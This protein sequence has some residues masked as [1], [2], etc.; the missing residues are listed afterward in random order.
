M[1]FR[2]AFAA[3]AL[4]LAGAASA[5]INDTLTQRRLS[6]PAATVGV[7]LPREDWVLL[8]EQRNA[9]G[10]VAYYMLGSE[11]RQLVL[12]VYLDRASSCHAADA[13]LELALKNTAYL[14]AH[15]L[16]KS[17]QGQFK[18]ARFFLDQPQGTQVRQLHLLATA[19]VDG[20]WIDVHISQTG[21]ERPD[22]APALDFLTKIA[23]W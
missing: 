5:D 12:S 6:L 19:Y 9:N 15:D 22:P 20:Q 4:C 17:E 8:K 1:N 21:R 16:Q 18:T 13:C 11:S 23:L 10:S 2:Y 3:L 14:D 7:V